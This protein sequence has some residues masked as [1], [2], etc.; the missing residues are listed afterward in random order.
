MM[1]SRV[2]MIGAMIKGCHHEKYLCRGEAFTVSEFKGL[3]PSVN[4]LPV[5]TY[6]VDKKRGCDPLH[7][8]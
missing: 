2:Y 7:P 8:P 3:L 1:I 6:G 4:A 5:H